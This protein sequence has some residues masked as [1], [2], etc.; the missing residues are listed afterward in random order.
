MILRM[1]PWGSG[2][3]NKKVECFDENI[4]IS[5]LKRM[6]LSRR[7]TLRII[8]TLQMSE[9]GATASQWMDG[10]QGQAQVA[11]LHADILQGL[12]LQS[13]DAY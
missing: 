11:G 1:L 7:E 2:E 8:L 5:K 12:N 6:V 3:S 10:R 9:L 13:T 4:F